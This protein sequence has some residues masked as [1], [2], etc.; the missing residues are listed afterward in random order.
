MIHNRARL[1]CVL[2]GCALAQPAMGEVFNF[3]WA[4]PS[5]DFI[6]N[7]MI[8]DTSYGIPGGEVNDAAGIIAAMS[9]SYDTDLARFSWS[10]TFG[11]QLDGSPFHTTN[12]LWLV[13]TPGV[14]PLGLGEG[15]VAQLFFDGSG[16]DPVLTG[17]AYNGL[18]DGSSYAD[19]SAEDGIQAP[20]GILSS[21]S[22]P[23]AVLSLSHVDN[24]DGTT[25]MSFE[26]DAGVVNDHI[27]LYAGEA[28]WTGVAFGDLIGVWMHTFTNVE[29][30]YEDGQLSDFGFARHGWVDGE[31]LPAPGALALFAL[32]GLAAR[33][34]RRS[35]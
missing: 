11:G 21:I 32:A 33:R 3:N 28:P 7:N 22:D 10:V 9:A 23:A 1:M 18:G 25:T 35:C 4:R 30:A 29:S 16:I 34:R 8:N 31:N 2:L 24:G 13:V 27:P 12:G 19:G 20:D 26:I 5:D 6:A 15:Q 17:Y 14:M